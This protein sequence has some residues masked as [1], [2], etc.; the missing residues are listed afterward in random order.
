MPLKSLILARI[1]HIVCTWI[2]FGFELENFS[3]YVDKL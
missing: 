3:V 1:E 2:I